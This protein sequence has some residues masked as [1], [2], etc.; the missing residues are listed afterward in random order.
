MG[1]LD[2]LSHWDLY[3]KKSFIVVLFLLSGFSIAKCQFLEMPI[4]TDSYPFVKYQKNHIAFCDDSSGFETVFEKMDSILMYGKGKLSIVHFGGSHIQADMYTSYMRNY[5]QQM[6]YDCNA[7]RGLLTPYKL[8]NTN[9][10]RNYKITSNGKWIYGS[11]VRPDYGLNYGLTGLTLGLLS[12]SI[13]VEIDPNLD[14][15]HQVLFDEIT[16]FHSFHKGF[17]IT[18]LND[19]VP[20]QYIADTLMGTS[21]FIFDKEIGNLKLSFVKDTNCTDTAEIYGFELGRKGVGI[22]YHTVGV[23]GA[24]FRSYLRATNMARQLK[25]LNPDLFIFSIGTNDANVRNF[26]AEIYKERY[27]GFVDSLLTYC[28]NATLLFTV[29][30]D[31]R[32]YG[33]YP[34]RNTA[35]VQTAIKELACEYNAGVWDFYDIMG[36]FRSMEKWYSYG[37]ARPD[38]IHFNKKGYAFKGDMLFNAFLNAY[39][40]HINYIQGQNKLT[41]N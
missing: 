23:N 40:N 19:T 41:D 22:V 5:L 29:P 3:S 28:P 10:P 18:L 30:N 25:V 31:S 24:S 20:F 4:K 37:M 35:M 39:N 34:N 1:K 27:T 17:S 38:H 15:N 14:S 8:A 16:V 12:D 9:N 33:K 36:G 21:R 6:C 11:M 7:G 2:R 32:L 26:N 13:E